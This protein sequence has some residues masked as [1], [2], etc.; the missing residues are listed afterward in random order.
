MSTAV[1]K[2]CLGGCDGPVPTSHIRVDHDHG[3]ACHVCHDCFVSA[4]GA[5]TPKLLRRCP[6]CQAHRLRKFTQV[7]VELAIRSNGTVKVKKR[8][9]QVKWRRQ[10]RTTRA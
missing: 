10:A 9:T 5:T 6:G 7:K 3:T 8:S 2:L 4:I 1:C